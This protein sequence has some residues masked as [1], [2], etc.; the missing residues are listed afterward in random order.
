MFCVV[1][2]GELHALL[3]RNCEGTWSHFCRRKLQDLFTVI[4]ILI[5]VIFLSNIRYKEGR[6]PHSDQLT[7]ETGNIYYVS[8]I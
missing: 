2:R 4:I 5:L 8:R 6:Q 7:Y 1:S 3:L